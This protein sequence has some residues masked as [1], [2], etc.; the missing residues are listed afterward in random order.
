MAALVPFGAHKGYGL[1]LINE[2]VAGLI[3]GSLPTLR[4][5]PIPEGEKRSCCFYFSVIHPDAL[6]SGLFAKGR[7][8][9]ENLKA[10]LGD[11]FGHGNESCTLPGGPE[12]K[13]AAATAAA[14]GLLFSAPEIEEFNALA[15][16]C[17]L[18]EWDL[19][20]FKEA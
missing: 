11:V 6:S 14:G 7:T 1:A 4:S 19:A 10:V 12:A 8:Q 13:A 17:G 20:N 16:E 5:R 3:G 18:P 15:R 9:G 2:L